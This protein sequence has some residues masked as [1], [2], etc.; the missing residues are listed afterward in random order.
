MADPTA[1]I[2]GIKALGLDPEDEKKILG[3][4]LARIFGLKGLIG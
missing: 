1:E 4:N 3:G 2:I